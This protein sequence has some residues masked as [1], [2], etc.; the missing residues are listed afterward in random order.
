MCA[1]SQGA[2]AQRYRLVVTLRIGLSL[3]PG[4]VRCKLG[5]LLGVEKT[6]VFSR[7]PCHGHFLP[8]ECAATLL[9]LVHLLLHVH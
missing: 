4:A 3:A 8:E 9:L 1:H 5:F 6:Q 2:Q 7:L